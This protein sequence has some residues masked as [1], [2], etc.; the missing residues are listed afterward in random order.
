M[1][2]PPDKV[3]RKSRAK[4]DRV[5]SLVGTDF[6]CVHTVVPSKCVYVVVLHEFVEDLLTLAR[7]QCARGAL[8]G[9]DTQRKTQ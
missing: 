8:V 2:P 4:R 9:R 5:A 1:V 7:L 6:P 3:T